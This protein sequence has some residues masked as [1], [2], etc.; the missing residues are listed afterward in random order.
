MSHDPANDET[1]LREELVAYLDGEL[2]GEQSRRVEQRAAVEPD[3]R[4]MLE[5]LDRTWQML[6]ELDALPTGE[7]FTC[8]T[9][10]MV[11]LAAADD[12]QKAKAALPRRRLWARLWAAGGL[13]GAAATGFLI[14]TSLISDP[15]AQLLQDLPILESFDPYREIEGIDFLRALNAEKLFP[16]DADVCPVTVET[17][18]Q[19]RRRVEKMSAEQLDELLRDEQQFRALSPQEQQRIRDLHDRIETASDR[20][21]L[22]ATM[23]RYDKW[24]ETQPPFRRAMLLDK[25]KTLKEHIA[26]VKE[27]LAKQDP[28]KGL[29]VDDQN[30]REL[31]EQLANFFESSRISDEERDRLMSLPGDEMYDSLSKQYR[32][33]MVKQS[34][35]PKPPRGD[36]PPGQ[37]GHH[38]GAPRG[39]DGRRWHENRDEKDPR[40]GKDSKGNQEGPAQGTGKPAAKK[41][42][43]EPWKEE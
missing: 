35:S 30:R 23:N 21:M 41:P 19:R 29:R 12:A 34:K 6:D 26:T 13:V 43:A 36:R 16:E 1:K 7:D 15:N 14:V 25:K 5:E 24:F 2:D 31:D 18:S 37:H 22:R 32:A 10:E 27:F 42:A 4:R 9:L 8:T 20:D 3:A 38:P 40:A 33:Y 28:A 11:A 17:L 39:S